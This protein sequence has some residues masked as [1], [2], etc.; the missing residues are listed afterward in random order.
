MAPQTV[1][2]TDSLHN[3]TPYFAFILL[4]TESYVALHLSLLY[5]VETLVFNFIALLCYILGYFAGYNEKC[6]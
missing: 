5:F 3:T 6:S 4:D 2:L 1:I